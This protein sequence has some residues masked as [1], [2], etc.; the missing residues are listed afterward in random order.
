MA[1]IEE[2]KD[3]IKSTP[4]TTIVNFY[5]PISKR[6]ANFEGICPFHADTKPSLKINDDKGIYKCFVCGAAGDAIKFVQDKM[7]LEFVDAIKEIST[8]IGVD[9][10]ETSRKNKDPKF[11]MALRVLSASNKIYRKVATE[12]TPDSFSEFKKSRGLSDESLENFQIGYAPKNSAVTSYLNSLPNDQKNL[13]IDV[14][15]QIGIIRINQR[16]QG[17]YDFFRD[18]VTF[19]IWDHAG[20]IRGYSSRAVL[21]DQM[22]KY[23]NSGESFIFDKGNILFGYN[24]AKNHIREK[25]SVLLVEGNMDVIMLHQYGFKNSVATQGVAISQNSIKLLGNMTKNIFLAMDSDPAGLVAMGKINAAFLEDG[26]IAK[27]LNFAPFK[28]PDEYLIEKGSLELQKLIEEAPSFIDYRISEI[29][30]DPI[31][32][33]TDKKLGILQEI[34][35]LVSPLKLNLMATEK[36]IQCAKSLGLKSNAEDITTEYK[37]FLD[38]NVSKSFAAHKKNHITTQP[39]ENIVPIPQENFMPTPLLETT[40]ITKV[41]R[42]LLETLL[43][44]PECI[45]HPQIVEILDFID[46]FEVKRIVQWLRK[47][48]LEIDE[49]DYPLFVQEKLKET[50]PDQIKKVMSS[51]L[52]NYDS[53]KLNEKIIN[54]MIGDL[55]HKLKIEDL[56]K[57]RDKLRLAQKECDTDEASLEVIKEIQIVEKKLSELRN[58]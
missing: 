56:I 32:S 49:A 13:A 19:P 42:I 46:H 52:F 16:G 41:Q 25:D 1:S 23:L 3:I 28:D 54:K 31:P 15:A 53:L 44:H 43:T 4:I 11:D 26:L 36:I 24:F 27:F 5:H 47:I 45:E 2:A 6:G 22:P 8:Q 14:G 35:S 29:I 51:S 20:K 7:N 37:K 48:Y 55:L 34:F 39:T 57:E 17:H 12:H 21:K 33:A 58:K 40:E 38:N 18:R 9:I 50:L 30:K 10:E